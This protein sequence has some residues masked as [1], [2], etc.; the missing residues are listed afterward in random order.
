[1]K[2]LEKYQQDYTKEIHKKPKFFCDKTIRNRE[3]LLIAGAMLE[4]AHEENGKFY[5]NIYKMVIKQYKQFQN[6][7][8]Q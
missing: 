3:L 1:M 7:Q 6:Q 4:K 5:L 2:N 8:K